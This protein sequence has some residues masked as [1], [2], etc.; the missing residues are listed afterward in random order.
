MH[1]VS[2]G[3]VSDN[4]QSKTVVAAV[5][6]GHV[7]IELWMFVNPMCEVTRIDHYG[8]KRTVW[9]FNGKTQSFVVDFD[10]L[11]GIVSIEDLLTA[12][13]AKNMPLPYYVSQTG[14]SNFHAC[15]AGKFNSWPQQKIKW[16]LKKWANIDSECEDSVELY[17]RLLDSG[18]DTNYYS[19]HY[20]KHKIRVPGSINSNHKDEN[21]K[22]WIVSGWRNPRYNIA[23]TQ[24]YEETA[25]PRP[26][27]V[28]SD[29]V[30]SIS[31]NKTVV[32]KFDSEPF[33]K[34]ISAMIEDL[35]PNKI[36]RIDKDKLSKAIA[37]NVN[38]LVKN[39]CK[40]TQTLWAEE[41]G[42]QQPDISRLLKT[43]VSKNILTKI[44][45]DYQIGEFAKTYGAG[46]R[47]IDAI[48]WTGYSLAGRRN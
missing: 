29:N 44:S 5:N 6:N 33:I 10:N 17:N 45:D 38:F 43:L 7:D 25:K 31:L 21:G 1:S 12:M 20:G 9:D 3:H 26:S 32:K 40:I 23:D 18:I 14:P 8:Q 30:K 41:I 39:K 19:Q 15:Y 28:P 24:Y 27:H 13:V 42:C 37:N 47:L 48:G 34:P 2:T 16:L 22:S 35:L 36:T 11:V 4:I 46:A